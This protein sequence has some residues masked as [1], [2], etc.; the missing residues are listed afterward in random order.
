MASLSY[1]RG[2][3]AVALLALLFSPVLQAKAPAD[4][5]PAATARAVVHKTIE[6]V[7]A[8]GLYPRKQEE[9]AAAKASLLIALGAAGDPVD[10]QA[11]FQHVTTLLHTLDTDGHSFIKTA[12]VSR[13]YEQHVDATRTPASS[14][15]LVPTAHG[16]ALH[17]TPPQSLAD[18]RID[19]PLFLK[20]FNSDYAATPGA[21]QACALVVDLSAQ[22]GG[23]AWP[24]LI[25]MR[26]LFGEGNP[27]SWVL[28]DGKRIAYVKPAELRLANTQYGGAA[29]NPLQRFS[30]APFAVVVARNTASAG[31]MLLIALMGEGARARSFGE[32]SYGMTTANKTHRLPD[33]SSLILTS[34]RYAIGDAPIIRGGIPPQVPAKPGALASET[35][36]QAA[37]WAAQASPMCHQPST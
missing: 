30:G 27:A 6:L 31:E 34:T 18:M 33:G 28:R 10:R 32:T 17:W 11:L 19:A 15:A 20:R 21:D 29:G 14:F 24:P 36:R 9:Y 5:I 13:Q 3:S 12:S 2:R 8:E 4:P 25:A 23:N 22:L 7:E 35:V 37:E 1:R 16:Q 26:P